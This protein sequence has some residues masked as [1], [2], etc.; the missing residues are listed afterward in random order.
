[1]K[2][3]FIFFITFVILLFCLPGILS[4]Q[5]S[6]YG[7]IP[8]KKYVW[9]G[10]PDN[11][12][13]LEK[14]RPVVQIPPLC[15][16]K[17]RNLG[18]D[19]ALPFGTT[20]GFTYNKQYYNAGDLR[21]TSDSTGIYAVGEA[22]VQNST[23]GEMKIIFR[24]DVWLLPILNVYGL[25]GYAQRTTSPN[26]EVPEITIKNLPIVGE[27]TLDTTIIINDEQIFYSPTYGG[28]ATISAGFKSFFFVLDYNYMIT[29]PAGMP[30]KMESHNFSGK[31]GVLLGHNMK[32]V[33]GSFWAGVN[34][35]NDNH[36]FSGEIDVKDIL[37]ELVLLFGE[38]ATYSG[39][40]TAKQY[41][42]IVIGGSVIINKHQLI[43]LEIGYFKRE[44]LSL[45][46]GFRF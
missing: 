30:D 7:I 43:A 28:G 19:L 34:Y 14:A 3:R 22:N 35:I 12:E 4:G 18:H 31:I 27:I 29:K 16:K 39:T 21:L 5:Q 17:R 1:M 10:K 45:T 33:K 6:D 44:Q 13:L 46:Y 36:K 9:F 38:K 32:V 41:W 40:L 2:V 26:F 42:N 25:F 37:P 23:S 24:P 11:S 20:A 8:G 15:G